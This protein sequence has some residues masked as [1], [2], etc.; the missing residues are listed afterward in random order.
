MP[1]GIDFEEVHAGGVQR[2][3]P[4]L[5]AYLWWQTSKWRESTTVFWDLKPEGGFYRLY[6]RVWRGHVLV[7]DV[8]LGFAIKVGSSHDSCGP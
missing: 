7:A 1:I 8:S 6:G 4:Y 3:L 5:R 2:T